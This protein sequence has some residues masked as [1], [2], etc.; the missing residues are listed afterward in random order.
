M[1]LLIK[2]ALSWLGTPYIWGGQSR[3]GV[4]CSGL[5]QSIL[6]SVGAAPQGDYTSQGLY[7]YFLA[8]GVKQSSPKAGS[9]IFY[10]TSERIIHVAF[11]LD[12]FRVIEAGGGTSKV[13]TVEDA[14][15]VGAYVRIRPYNY[16]KDVYAI[17]TPRYQF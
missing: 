7:L 15:S 13:K 2:Y 5:V 3:Y 8:Q 11:A 16:R 9:L 4:D 14:I 10:G 1:E 12:D 6:H 17:I